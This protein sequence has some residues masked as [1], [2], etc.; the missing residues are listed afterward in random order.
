[1]ED[2]KDGQRVNKYLYDNSPQFRKLT[3]KL[4]LLE[5]VLNDMI[6]VDIAEHYNKVKKCRIEIEQLKLKHLLHKG[7]MMGIKDEPETN[8]KDYPDKVTKD[9]NVIG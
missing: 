6:D 8:E 3:H 9:T 4:C 7:Y 1:M 5:D 2:L